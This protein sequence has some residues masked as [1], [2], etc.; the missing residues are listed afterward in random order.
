MN[1]DRTKKGCVMEPKPDCSKC[2]VLPLKE[3]PT[4]SSSGEVA[5]YVECWVAECV[6][7]GELYD[8]QGWK[9][10]QEWLFNTCHECEGPLKAKFIKPYST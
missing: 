6:H 4:V 8:I 9:G 2:G 7:C 5:G 3:S 1:C 10:E